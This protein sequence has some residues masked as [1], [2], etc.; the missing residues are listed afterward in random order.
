MICHQCA[1]TH[2][3]EPESHAQSLA[4]TIRCFTLH[5]IALHK[6][7]QYIDLLYT[8]QCAEIKFNL[9]IS[10]QFNHHNKKLICIV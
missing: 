10:T 5:I 1:N 8:T 7:M 4:H 3:V 9:K 6:N 2:V